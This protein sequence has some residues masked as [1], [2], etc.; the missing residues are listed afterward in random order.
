[1]S[2]NTTTETL[3]TAVVRSGL[4]RRTL[5]NLMYDGSIDTVKVRGRR[6]IVSAS[7]NRLL[8]PD[9]ARAA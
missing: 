1:M 3:K 4:C 2:V 5:Y 9:Q 7:L 8:L 6:L